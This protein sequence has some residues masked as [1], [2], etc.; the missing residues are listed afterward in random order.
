[1]AGE[2]NGEVREMRRGERYKGTETPGYIERTECF[3][4]FSTHR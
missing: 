3:D 2:F 4:T 1:M